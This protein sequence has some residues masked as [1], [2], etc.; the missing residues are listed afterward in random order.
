MN[1]KSKRQIVWG[2][3]IIAIVVIGLF[4]NPPIE[5]SSAILLIFIGS[6]LLCL[7]YKN[8]HRETHHHDV[9]NP[10]MQRR[11]DNH[12]II[13]VKQVIESIDIINSTVNLETFIGRYEYLRDYQG[14][15]YAKGVYERLIHIKDQAPMQYERLI[16]EG[17]EMY[18]QM[19][20]DKVVSEEYIQLLITPSL[21]ALDTFAANSMSRCYMRYVQKMERE[22]NELKTEKAKERRRFFI[23]EKGGVALGFFDRLGGCNKTAEKIVRDLIRQ[24][25]MPLVVQ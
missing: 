19:Y 7:G 18:R 13:M 11:M 17:L 5:G 20:Y 25:S 6:I 9:E 15:N 22:I 4:T 16:Q 8:K 24:Y 14:E 1:K 23:I 21:Q 2:Y 3:I 12:N 10:K